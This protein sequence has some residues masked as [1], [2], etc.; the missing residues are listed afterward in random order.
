MKETFTIRDP[1]M[2][3]LSNPF[4]LII[5]FIIAGSMFVFYLSPYF[6]TLGNFIMRK[7][8]NDHMTRWY[9]LHQL[10][11]NGE[12]L[13]VKFLYTLGAT[14]F[15]S[16]PFISLAT[17]PLLGILIDNIS[18]AGLL[19][20]GFMILYAIA[21]L[22]PLMYYLEKFERRCKGRMYSIVIDA[23]TNSLIEDKKQLGPD[24]DRMIQYK[25]GVCLLE[26][27]KL[28]EQYP[29]RNPMN[30]IRKAIQKT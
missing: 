7:V 26:Y 13:L 24:E 10:R 2:V 15:F 19:F 20:I 28:R 21:F 25:I 22:A 23:M 16:M 29:L 1:L 9:N 12:R 8:Y 11:T 14:L 17:I 30:Y 5:G 18:L 3:F 27:S 6:D 4:N